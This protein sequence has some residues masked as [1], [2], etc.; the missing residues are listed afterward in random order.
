[1]TAAFALASSTTYT[2]VSMLC[3]PSTTGYWK[4][5]SPDTA[6]ASAA[7]CESKCTADARCVAFEYERVSFEAGERECEL[8]DATSYDEAASKATGA[9]KEEDVVDGWRCCRAKYAKGQTLNAK[10][11]ATTS[12]GVTTVSVGLWGG[13]ASVAGTVYARIAVTAVA[14]VFIAFS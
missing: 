10:G 12:S 1:M 7:A 4:A 5:L 2:P 13:A 3:R 11:T 6:A 14:A 9:C 8:H